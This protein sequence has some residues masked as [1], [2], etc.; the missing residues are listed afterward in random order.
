MAGSVREPGAPGSKA[1]TASRTQ[2]VYG[3]FLRT[4]A[5]SMEQYETGW[6]RKSG[7]LK[8]LRTLIERHGFFDAVAILEG[9]IATVGTPTRR[10][11]ELD[12]PRTRPTVSELGE[13][14][15]TPDAFLHAGRRRLREKDFD[16]S[17][18]GAESGELPP[19]WR[20]RPVA[21]GPAEMLGTRSRRTLLV[22]VAAL[23]RELKLDPAERGTAKTLQMLTEKLGAPVSDDAIK[24][25]LD[26]IAGAIRSRAQRG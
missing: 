13:A 24:R 16:W 14:L 11:D 22:L 18:V 10:R 12:L 15:A 5:A 6:P 25:Y 20:S 4:V 2:A 8:T 26:E 19:W 21:E 3:W 23:C 17:E 1:W 9:F 7:D